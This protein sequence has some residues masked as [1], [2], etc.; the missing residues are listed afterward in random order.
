VLTDG[1]RLHFSAHS[2]N[3]SKGAALSFYPFRTAFNIWVGGIEAEAAKC[4]RDEG[5]IG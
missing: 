2:G 5:R 4:P 1:C 3:P